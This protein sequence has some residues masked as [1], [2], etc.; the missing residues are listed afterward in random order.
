MSGA[1]D[2]V[3]Q[4]AVSA[5]EAQGIRPPAAPVGALPLRG[6]PSAPSASKIWSRGLVL[7]TVFLVVWLLDQFANLLMD[8]WLLEGLGYEDVF[9]TN[10][11]VEAVLF[12]I[13]LVAVTAAIS[14]PAFLAGLSSRARK[15]M[16]A[17]G[18][19]TGI[20]AGVWLASHYREFLLLLDGKPFGREDPVYGNDVGFYVFDL[21][22][23]KTILHAIED[24]AIIAIVAG[25]IA[26][27]LSTKGQVRPSG[28]GR[29]RRIIG[30]AASPY[31]LA[32]IAVLGVALAVD[33]W[34]HRYDLLLK[35]NIDSSIYNGAQAID[36]TGIFSSKN[37]LWVESFATLLGTIGII[38]TLR[39][40]REGVTKEGVTHWKTR[41]APRRMALALLPGLVLT[42][43]VQAGVSLRDDFEIQPNE[44]VVQLP[45]I[46]RHIDATNFAYGMDK[47]ET[48]QFTPNGAGDPVPSL[49]S[50]LDSP[51]IKNAPL[52]P[53]YSASLER[54]VDPEYLDRLLL[55]AGDPSIYQPT[56]QVYNQQQKLR[57]YYEFMDMDTVRYKV[58][59]ESRLFAS[60]ARE[61]PLVE[62]QPWL[63]WW[64]QRYMVFTHGSGLVMNLLRGV[65]NEGYPQY[66]S[67]DIP[68]KV[69]APELAVKNPAIY[70]GEGA[71][72]M[73]YSNVQDLDEHDFP[74]AEG[75]AQI[76]YPK[77]VEA[78]VEL[79][80]WVK[81]A[82]FGWKSR[83]FLEIFFSDLMKDDSRVHYFRTPLERLEKVAPF[84]W[85]DTDPYAV[86]N[87][88]RVTWMVNGLTHSNNYPYSMRGQLGDK[89]YVRT[90]TP[91]NEIWTNY[92][93][94]SVKATVDGFTGDIKLYQWKD[95]PV[96]NTWADIYPDLFQEKEAMPPRLVDQV[97]YPPQLMHLQFDDLYVFTHMKDPLT[98]FS[99]EDLYDDGDE[100][101]GP[102]LGEGGEAINF[103]IEPY[104]WMA[105]TTKG[106]MPR[107]APP[108]QFSLST[109]F[110]PENSLNLRSIITAYQE[111]RDYGRLHELQV[112]KGEF[113]PGPEQADAAIDQDPFISQQF[114]LWSR[115]GLEV[116]RGHTTPLL[117]E[118]E[119]LYIEPI[120]VRSVQNPIPQLERVVVVFRGDAFM[121]QT[122]EDALREAVVGRP[123]F[124]IRP[125]PELGG[126]P[127]FD[128]NGDRQLTPGDV[129]VPGRNRGDG[130]SLSDTPVFEEEGGGQE[131]RGAGPPAGRGGGE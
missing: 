127:G 4:G 66:L 48:K 96:V 52:W 13:A 19:L 90:P 80:S 94:D 101:K 103:S 125:G 104:N 98:F 11:Q 95:E 74:T 126:E 20:L 60:S 105:D 38:V 83:Q 5:T 56:N 57:P 87:G 32:S 73:A 50:L 46:K 62:P 76:A 71:G 119:L 114:A 61:L 63:A 79:D 93:Q 64:G 78:G 36:V 54:Q 39:A 21:P 102:I 68:S 8:Y 31:V 81:Q 34:L 75:R 124:P 27:V 22:A 129:P 89:S 2:D 44:P 30:R 51:A 35:E 107:S 47:V 116:I 92:V 17:I 100:V 88:D 16:I 110:T 25:V 131:D 113:H 115:T 130:G 40:L 67:R 58:N 72:S 118:N 70:Y 45:Y 77:D 97:Q 106:P 41:T 123:Q 15:H 59:G 111:G 99:Q 91:R 55:K 120:F 6:L 28:F 82:V 33:I 18:V 112:P 43:I 23:I 14:A 69:D 65:S 37:A 53:G 122:L 7:F 9:W 121:G 3:R 128:P 84:L 117:V 49:K 10:F 109:I 24:V 26:S 42:F 1:T 29:L 86:T 85:G 12:V 108:Q